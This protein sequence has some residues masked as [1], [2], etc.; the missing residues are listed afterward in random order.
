MMTLML[1][2]MACCPGENGAETKLSEA[3]FKL[4]QSLQ[5]AQQV[6][7]GVASLAPE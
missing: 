3:D 2:V 6:W 1:M 5:T 4:M 7:T